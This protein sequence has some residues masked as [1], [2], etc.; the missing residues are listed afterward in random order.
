MFDLNAHVRRVA[1]VGS[2]TLRRRALPTGHCSSSAGRSPNSPSTARARSG[3]SRSSKGCTAGAPRCSRRSTTRSPTAWAGSVSRSRSSTSS[4][5]LRPTPRPP[6]PDIDPEADAPHERFTPLRSTRDAVADATTRNVGMARR[7]V[8]DTTRVLTHPLRAP[9]P[10]RGHRPPPP[11]AA[12]AAVEHR[13]RP[14]RRDAGPLAQP[15]LRDVHGVALGAVGRGPQ[16]R[17]EHQRHV[18]RRARRRARPLPRAARELGRRASPRDADQH[19]RPR[20]RCGEPVRA[21]AAPRADPA[22]RR[23][24][25]ALR[26]R[27]RAATAARRRNRDQRGRRARRVPHRTPHR[28]PRGHDALRRPA[29]PTSPP[30]ICAAARS[31]SS[32]RAPRCSRTSRSVREPEP[33]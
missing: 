26:R 7:A 12:T 8:G 17:R 21:R 13:S 11:L 2:E 4:R 18:H 33:R 31:R 3:S 20:R 25:R 28:V 1:L 16:A 19:P 15:A 24:G 23:S 14:F 5:K 30:P 32:S 6:V 22:R 10:S 9:G 27:S 29:P